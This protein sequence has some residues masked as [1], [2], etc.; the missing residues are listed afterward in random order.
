MR[1]AYAFVIFFATISLVFAATTLN[2]HFEVVPELIR[3]N[4][5][6]NYS[7]DIYV[8]LNKTN[9]TIQFLNNTP[10]I[11]L[12]LQQNTLTE[13]KYD[14][15]G[16]KIYV[17]NK[18]ETAYNN[19]LSNYSSGSN[20]TI[21]L[22]DNRHLFCRP[23]RYY[24]NSFSVID[25]NNQSEYVNL[26]IIVDIPISQDGSFD[27]SIQQG[28]HSFY[29]NSSLLPESASVLIN[30]TPKENFGI[31]LFDQ[32]NLL[33]YSLEEDF[34]SFIEK[35]KFY[36]IKLV[37]D[38]SYKGNI[39]LSGIN[40]SLQSINFGVLNVT[41]I[42]STI[43]NIKNQADVYE[44]NIQEYFELYHIDRFSDNKATNFTF[45]VP[46]NVSLI[47]AV[48]EW[49][50]NKT[51]LINLYNTTNNIVKSSFSK[52]NIFKNVS[53]NPQEYLVFNSPETGFWKLEVKNLTLTSSYNVTIYQ[54][55]PSYVY[56]NFSSA[57][58]GKDEGIYVN[59]TLQI[60]SF[61]LNGEYQG[62]VKYKSNRGAAIKIPLYF[63]VT[64]PVL[65][66]N[67]TLNFQ[68]IYLKENY[69]KNST[70]RLLIPLNNTGSQNVS[71]NIE[72]SGKLYYLNESIDMTH[73]SDIIIENNSSKY[74]SINFT[75]NSSN[76]K[77]TYKG[78]LYIN[79][80]GSEQE[81]SHPKSDYNISIEFT[82]TDEILVNILDLRTSSNNHIINN[83][84]KDQNVTAKIK[85][86]YINGTEIE[87]GNQLNI[88]NFE[89]WLYHNNL[90]YRVPSNG[91]L[92]LENKTNP[93]YLDGDYEINFT[94]PAKTLGGYYKTYVKANWSTNVLYH[95]TGVNSSLF[96]NNTA[97]YMTTSNSTSI[98]MEPNKVTKFVA[99][100]INY[101][102]KPSIY[103]KVKFN[104]SCDGYS[105]SSSETTC[106]GSYGSDEFTI[107]PNAY[108]SCYL[109][110]NIESGSSNASSCTARVFVTPEEGWLDP[111]PIN[112]SVIIRQNTNTPTTTTTE[113]EISIE[114]IQQQEEKYFFVETNTK[115][116]VEQGKNS[117]LNVKVRNLYSKS[118]TIKISLSSINNTWFRISPSENTISKN[119]YYIYRIIFSIPEDVNLGDYKGKLRIESKYNTQDIDITLTV[120][121][122]DKLKLLI[123]STING[124]ESKLLELEGI[125]NNTKN[126]TLK[127]KLEEIR[128]KINELKSYINKGDYLS[129]YNNL[130]D[131]K[132]LFDNLTINEEE[133]VIKPKASLSWPILLIG[134]S[135]ILFASALGYTAFETMKK[136]GFSFKVK[137]K[138]P[139]VDTRKELKEIKESLKLKELEEE[140]KKV[141]EKEKEL[142]EEIKSIEEKEKQLEKS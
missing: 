5:T 104:E 73:P 19:I 37:G 80:T 48:V 67:N 12:Y 75:Y 121:P 68:N 45:L 70:V 2:N 30:T 142:E 88:S 128:S 96:I 119:D 23:G 93:L 44:Q 26:T 59:L 94:V 34:V 33:K 29:F 64:T 118:Q 15:Q 79:S 42:N 60:P 110:W 62:F 54:Y 47:K 108:S 124:Y 101:G 50:G 87:A 71:L 129:A 92:K 25:Q 21:S 69:G 126:E 125:I 107:M 116:S 136:K 99:N 105:I 102:E 97:L 78:W 127:E 40:S 65:L 9:L 17:F 8:F 114:E 35:D 28:Y 49:E 58:L 11:P 106:T 134:G 18:N 51:Y 76:P 39:I 122:G 13:C 131:V 86:F 27:G 113:E 123:N 74:L 115:I 103:Y 10:F 109:V 141:K 57:N 89:I 72:S 4:W 16:Y 135:G 24:T 61:A 14:N 132:T 137:S 43:I 133:S 31:F 77:G 95:G 6:N 98:T 36:E 84:S 120:L 63:N 140:I 90:T 83:I 130:Y 111:S 66:V 81:R 20:I 7:S 117:T 82:L 52:Q 91:G 38:Q 22:L 56:S 1:V 85:L 100:I 55:V 3:L 138:T 53:L 139:K 32:T 112:V 41:Q 46:Y